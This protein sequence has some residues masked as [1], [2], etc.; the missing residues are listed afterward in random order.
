[1]MDLQREIE[2]R[3]GVELLHLIHT[4][5]SQQKWVKAGQETP[6]G[7]PV[8]HTMNVKPGVGLAFM[9]RDGRRISIGIRKKGNDEKPERYIEFLC[10]LIARFAA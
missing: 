2:Q 8:Y 10:D 3:T 1:M 5:A 9:H 6:E 4:N 7:K